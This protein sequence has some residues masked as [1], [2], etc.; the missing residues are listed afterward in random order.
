MGEIGRFLAGAVGGLAI[1]LVFFAVYYRVRRRRLTWQRQKRD[2]ISR[3]EFTARVQHVRGEPIYLDPCLFI[4]QGDTP[5]ER[6]RDRERILADLHQYAQ[7]LN[8]HGRV[9]AVVGVPPWMDTTPQW[10]EEEG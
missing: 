2:A 5:Q 9:I 6:A 7:Q 3:V 10:R 4:P 1:Y 8:S